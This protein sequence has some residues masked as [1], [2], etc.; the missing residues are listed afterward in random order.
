M[1]IVFIIIGFLGG[2]LGGMGMGGG[3]LLIPMLTLLGSVEQIL[4]Q[5]INLICFLPMSICSIF[6]HIKNHLIDM[7]NLY[8]L[9]IVGIIFSC[10]GS[11]VANKIDNNVLKI[12]FAVFLILLGIFQ[13][14]TIILSKNNNKKS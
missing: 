2:I 10:I 5:G 8:V 3:T 7:K 4:A 6:F 1:I 12:C 11:F 14:L 9:L 13:F